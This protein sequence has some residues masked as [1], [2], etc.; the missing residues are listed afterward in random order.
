M[1]KAGA[2]ALHDRRQTRDPML[3]AYKRLSP[4]QRLELFG[5]TLAVLMAAIYERRR[6]HRRQQPGFIAPEFDRRSG[7]DRRREGG[8]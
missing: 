2:E 3:P 4:S 5:D 1:V 6:R 7:A 8:G